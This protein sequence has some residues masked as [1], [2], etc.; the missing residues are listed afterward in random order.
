MIVGFDLACN[1]GIARVSTKTRAVPVTLRLDL[2]R[3]T[4]SHPL[5]RLSVLH[6]EVV[7]FLDES[8]RATGE[9]IEL[10]GVENYSFARSGP[11]SFTAGEFGGVLRMIVAQRRIPLIVVPPVTLKCFARGKKAAFKKSADFDKAQ[12]VAA[13]GNYP[14]FKMDPEED[15]DRSDALWV[16]IFGAFVMAARG[17]PASHP[18]VHF[19]SPY[20][21]EIAA[22]SRHDVVTYG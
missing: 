18:V 15:D 8:V 16:A 5:L 3:R 4:G 20:R 7:E 1:T 22:R 19:D 2:N 9:Q 11:G 21:R 17:A 12:M 6:A 10:L 14:G 13:L